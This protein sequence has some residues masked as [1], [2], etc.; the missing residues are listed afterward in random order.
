MA[1]RYFIANETLVRKIQRNQHKQKV[2]SE[3]IIG[4]L[5]TVIDGELKDF[6]FFTKVPSFTEH[7]LQLKPE[8]RELCT[9]NRNWLNSRKPES[10]VLIQD[11][12]KYR[13]THDKYGVL[14]RYNPFDDSV[15][16]VVRQA[17]PSGRVQFNSN[18]DGTLI[19]FESDCEN[20]DSTLLDE[21]TRKAYL[22]KL[23]VI[24]ETAEDKSS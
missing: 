19:V 16:S 21:I 10:K 3:V 9:K 14:K 4:W 11:W 8:L 20:P 15:E 24:E 12:L 6:Q 17:L 7:N 2:A 1:E 13:D 18:N 5:N 23:I 22:E